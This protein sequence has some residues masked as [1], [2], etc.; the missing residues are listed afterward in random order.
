MPELVTVTEDEAEIRLDRWFR[1]RFPGLPQSAIQKLC[2][3][4]QVRVDGHRAEP[5]T[6][7]APGQAV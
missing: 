4:G 1:R 5:A 2:R 7:L 3:T 6:R